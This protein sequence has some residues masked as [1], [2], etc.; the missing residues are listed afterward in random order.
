M[1]LLSAI[2]AVLMSVSAFGQDLVEYDNAAL[3]QNCTDL[4]GNQ[5]R[6]VIQLDND[7]FTFLTDNFKLTKVDSNFDTIWHNSQLD[8]TGNRLIKLKQLSMVGLLG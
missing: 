8:T 7:D 1:K 5:I 6:D 4:M 3:T 2:G